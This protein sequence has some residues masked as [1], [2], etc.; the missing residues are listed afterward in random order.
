[1]DEYIVHMSK[2]REEYHNS[3]I[4]T[5][6]IRPA[7]WSTDMHIY[8]K[9]KYGNLHF[10]NKGIVIQ[11]SN[12]VDLMSVVRDAYDSQTL[13]LEMCNNQQNKN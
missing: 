9:D 3:E 1:M 11:R 12:G 7:E 5:Y 8:W 13:S 4:V 2:E 6:P 10:K